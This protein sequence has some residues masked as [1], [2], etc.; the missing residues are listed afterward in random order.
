M[1]WMRCGSSD[2]NWSLGVSISSELEDWCR[3]YP[4]ITSIKIDSGPYGDQCG[5]QCAF[6]LS[7]LS[8]V[9]REAFL[10]DLE[11]KEDELYKLKLKKLA[12]KQV[13]K[14]LPSLVENAKKEF[15]YPVLLRIDLSEV[16][17]PFSMTRKIIKL[18]TEA[19]KADY[20]VNIDEDALVLAFKDEK[21][22]TLFDILS[23]D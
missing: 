2:S 4:K 23:C 6:K 14:C 22:K 9:D 19:S 3:S 11:K 21:T 12:M 17:D 20:R 7:F 5:D 16:D 1:A 8:E 18:A 13:R 15:L 10:N